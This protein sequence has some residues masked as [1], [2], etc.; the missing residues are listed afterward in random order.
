MCG[1]FRRIRS[2]PYVLRCKF[3]AHS[4]HRESR[5]KELLDKNEGNYQ[6]IKDKNDNMENKGYNYSRGQ[7]VGTGVGTQPLNGDYNV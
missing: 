3:C 4:Q 6:E 2:Y 7:Q 1:N 5:D